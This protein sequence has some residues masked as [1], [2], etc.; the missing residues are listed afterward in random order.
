MNELPWITIFL[1]MNEAIYQWFSRVTK[2]RV[3]IIGISHQEWPKLV[4]HGNGCIILYLA[5]SLPGV[6]LQWRHNERNG[7]SNHQSHDCLLNRLF[8]QKSKKTS[9]LQVTSLCA[10]NLPVTG[11]FPAQRASSAE[12]VSIWWRHHGMP[13]TK[14]TERSNSY[15][16]GTNSLHAARCSAKQDWH[17]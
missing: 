15:L 16:L 5:C 17:G 4:I 12:N 10:G 14:S 9:K 6:A 11:E 13:N 2:S 8:R 1:V 7:V 3:K